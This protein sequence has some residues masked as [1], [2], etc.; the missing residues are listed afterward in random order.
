[1]TCQLLPNEGVLAPSMAESE[2]HIH[3]H[4]HTRGRG[5]KIVVRL[6]FS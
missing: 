5:G 4:I 3:I 1:M 2:T 6:A